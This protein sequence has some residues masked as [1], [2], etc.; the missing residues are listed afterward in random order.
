VSHSKPERARRTEWHGTLRERLDLIAAVQHNCA[1][2]F[3]AS[4][5]SH[6]VCS[7]HEMLANDQRALDG[8]LW[9]RYLVDR[10]RMEEG[11]GR[12]GTARQANA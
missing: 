8:L 7:V 10:L 11:I 12:P 9:N 1:C 4:D 2:S 5:G 3:D 6:A